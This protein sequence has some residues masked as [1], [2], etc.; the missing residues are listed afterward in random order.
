M[1]Q[2]DNLQSQEKIENRPLDYNCNHECFIQSLSV[3]WNYGKGVSRLFFFFCRTHRI[4]KFPGQGWNAHH[5]SDS[6]GS[7]T[8]RATSALPRLL[9][10]RRT[11]LPA[12]RS[13]SG[14]IFSGRKEPRASPQ[15]VRVLRMAHRS[16]LWSHTQTAFHFLLQASRSFCNLLF[17]E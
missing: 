4:R 15:G 3:F 5:S 7:F 11:P 16:G 6:A 13:Q 17:G 2:S 12:P 14:E 8:C 9:S 1:I 10:T